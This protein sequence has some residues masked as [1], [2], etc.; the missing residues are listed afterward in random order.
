[1]LHIILI[2]NY[3]CIKL[4]FITVSIIPLDFIV[5]IGIDINELQVED[6]SYI[7]NIFDQI[8]FLLKFTEWIQYTDNFL[9][10]LN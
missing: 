1:M 6:G 2:Y 4:N 10:Q 9:L 8:F 5:G 7:G 3:F